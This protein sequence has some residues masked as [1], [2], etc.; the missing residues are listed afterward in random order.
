MPT[1]RDTLLV[2]VRPK[3]VQQ[4]IEGTK[5]AELRRVR[6]NVRVGQV[7]AAAGVTRAEYLA[8]FAG[9]ARASAIWLEQVSAFERPIAL[10]D[11]RQRWP[12]FRPPQSYC[13]V[14]ATF[15]APR[16]VTALAPRSAG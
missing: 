9:A 6:P 1:P 15:E 8:Y 12:W 10:R 3:F 7:R 11:L 4:I 13:Y 5:T 14:C 2:S 16:S